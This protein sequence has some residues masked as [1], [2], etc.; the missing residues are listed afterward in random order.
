MCRICK[1]REPENKRRICSR[2][3]NKQRNP[4]WYEKNK[5]RIIAKNRQRQK[6][7]RTVVLQRYGNKCVCCGETNPRF[8]TMDHIKGGGRAHRKSIASIYDYLNLKPLDEEQFQI[9]CFNCNCS[10]YWNNNIC[11][12]KQANEIA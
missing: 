10:K 7:I 9:L 12:H 6:V 2:C 8:L 3:H 5:E 11:P 4:D 1:E